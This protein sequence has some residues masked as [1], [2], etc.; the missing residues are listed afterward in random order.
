MHKDQTH[1]RTLQEAID[2][3]YDF[4]ISEIISE[5]WASVKGAKLPIFLIGLII[6]V[7]TVLLYLVAGLIFSGLSEQAAALAILPIELIAFTLGLGLIIVSLKLSNRETVNVWQDFLSFRHYF[8]PLCLM[9]IVT[10]LVTTLGFIL[11]IIPGIYLV[12][13]Y[14][15]TYWILIIHPDA[16]FWNIMEASRKIVTRHWFKFFFLNL[17]LGI[18]VSISAI[19]FG[20]GLIWTVPLFTLSYA[21]IFKKIFIKTP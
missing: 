9:V 13:A 8:W 17:I 21:T 2:Y 3:P 5:G 20:I 19:P 18:I 6:M 12:T 10:G 7:A 15:L 1:Y 14:S 4:S 11:L 16:G